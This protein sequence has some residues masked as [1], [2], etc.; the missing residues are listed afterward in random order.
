MLS[1]AATSLSCTRAR[2]LK[3]LVV[4]LPGLLSA[5]LGATEICRWVDASG[6]T[7]LSE[8]VPAEFRA[9]AV[10]IDSLTYELSPQEQRAANQQAHERELRAIRDG[11]RPQAAAAT[12][13]PA[14]L[15][16]ASQ[17]QA[18]RPAERV[19]D[20]TDCT[21]WWRLFDA[22]AA[23]FSAFRT[24]HGAI[25]AEAFDVCNAVASPEPTCGLRRD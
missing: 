18:K 25:K 16:S 11:I 2:A 7:Q 10:C 13:T 22:S 1:R 6:R 23:C 5:P 24:V 15:P 12:G 8:L 4:A 20:S 9:G 21:T 19:T 3:V 17:Q 14:P